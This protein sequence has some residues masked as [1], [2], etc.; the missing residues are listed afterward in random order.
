[1]LGSWVRAPAGSQRREADGLP[2]CIVTPTGIR[3]SGFR[4]V[5]IR[6]HPG[7]SVP[8][9][10]KMAVARSGVRFQGGLGR[11]GRRAW[12]PEGS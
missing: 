8:K 6:R 3:L 9:Q 1:M 10:V 4:Q 7:A 5:R 12:I 11:P 2:S